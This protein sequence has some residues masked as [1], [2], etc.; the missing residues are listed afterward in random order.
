MVRSMQGKYASASLSSTTTAKPSHVATSKRS[1]KRTTRQL[2]F[3][4]FALAA[5]LIATIGPAAKAQTYTTEHSFTSNES[6]DGDGGPLQAR[7]VIDS[8]GNFWG[9]TASGGISNDGTVF[10]I[11]SS[12]TYTTEHS[13]TDNKSVDGD[14]GTIMA[15]LVIDSSGNFWGTTASG[16]TSNDGTVFKITSI[17]TY[18]AEH[19]FTDNKSGDGDGGTPQAGL[20]IDSS[21]NFWGTTASGGTSNDGTVLKITS[22][23]TYTTEHSFTDNK[24]GDGDGGTP[25]AGLVI[26][27]SGN[28]WGTTASGGT[29]NDGTVLKITSSGTYTTEHSF[30]DNKSGDGDGGTPQA[31]LVIDSSGNFW[32]TTASG[33]TSN[34]GTVFKITS[35]GTYTTEHSFTDNK[36]GDGDGGT[37]QAGLVIDSSGNFWGTT[38][39][40]GTSTDGTV[41]KITSSGT[42]TAE[43]SFT[44][45]KSGNG[46]G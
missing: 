46:D 23:G 33:G 34:D 41:F 24:S 29:S 20:V 31:G 25:Q 13:F 1:A 17:G 37:P 38:A 39:S 40:G 22:S 36:S 15:G 27:S 43:H 18:T 8:S 42:Y 7:L 9:T 44:D 19:S 16:G 6:G 5:L 2:C 4:R 35:S 30:T 3:R 12:G 28:F 32:G 26:D 11:T 45:N 14:G 21:G 10:K